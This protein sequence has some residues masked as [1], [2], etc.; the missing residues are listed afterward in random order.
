MHMRQRIAQAAIAAGLG[1]SMVFGPV[2]A[3]LAAPDTPV[4]GESAAD[5]YTSQVVA[6]SKGDTKLYVISEQDDLTTS[7]G[8]ANENVRVTIPV[9]IHYVADAAG[10]LVGP[11]DNTV[12]FVNHTKLGAVHVS[13]IAVQNAGDASIKPDSNSL[14]ADEMSFFVQPV[15]GTSNAD[16]STFVAKTDGGEPVVGT[17]DQLGTYVGEGQDGAKA[18][19]Y[20]DDWNI[21][22]NDGALA[23]NHLTGRIGGFDQVS[24]ASDYQAGTVHW[25]VRAGTRAEAAVRDASV[26]VHFNSN[27]GSNAGCVPI[28]DQTVQ[29]IDPSTDAVISGSQHGMDEPLSPGASSVTPPKSIT[30]VDGTTTTYRFVGWSTS[31]AGGEGTMVEKIGDLGEASQIAGKV[32]EVYAIFGPAA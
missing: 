22:G 6:E 1:A 20:K 2:S 8:S 21:A 31:P 30:N 13:K 24:A 32:V 12:K 5:G 19:T 29:I 28:G 11:S 4:P 7:E 26:T 27:N 17:L 16:G 23:L 3:A 10:N 25:T 15:P 9:A 18:P 14:G